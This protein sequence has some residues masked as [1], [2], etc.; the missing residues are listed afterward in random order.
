MHD[1][2]GMGISQ[3]VGN[4]CDN[5]LRSSRFQRPV[6]DVCGERFT[7][8]EFLDEERRTVR[9]LPGLVNRDDSGMP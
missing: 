8:N 9:R 5:L 6:L 4:K 3:C 2:V 7:P 1:A